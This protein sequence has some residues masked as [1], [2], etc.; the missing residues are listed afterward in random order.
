MPRP[1]VTGAVWTA[2]ASTSYQL[3]AKCQD[4]VSRYYGRSISTPDDPGMIHVNRELLTLAF[5]VSTLDRSATCH[6]PLATIRRSRKPDGD[7]KGPR[8][9]G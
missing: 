5:A 1:P 6:L 9:S 4:F 3:N 2:D 8:S 7:T